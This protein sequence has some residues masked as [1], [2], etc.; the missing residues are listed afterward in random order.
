MFGTVPETAEA[1][2]VSPL[3]RWAAVTWRRRADAVNTAAHKDKPVFVKW[4]NAYP[5][6][7]FAAKAML[8][9]VPEIALAAA[10]VCLRVYSEL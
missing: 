9:V 2:V 7:V 6:V 4:A 3:T 10:P 5:Q 8:G 1:D